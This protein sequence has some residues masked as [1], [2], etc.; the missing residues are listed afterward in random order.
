MAHLVAAGLTELKLEEYHRCPYYTAPEILNGSR[1]R[2]K[3]ADVFS[4]AIVMAEVRHGR[5]PWTDCWLISSSP[6]H[7]FSILGKNSSVCSTSK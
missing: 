4:F 5:L 7:R 2:G 1:V 3:E 6:P